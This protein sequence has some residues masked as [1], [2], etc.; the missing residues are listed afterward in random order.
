MYRKKQDESLTSISG[1]CSNS[2]CRHHV[3]AVVVGSADLIRGFNR[4]HPRDPSLRIGRHA[5]IEWRNE[6]CSRSR[7]HEFPP[8]LLFL[9]CH[10][11]AG[12]GGY[13]H[14]WD[15]RAVFH[16]LV[17]HHPEALEAL[18]RTDGTTF[19]GRRRGAMFEP[20]GRREGKS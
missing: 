14:L 13:S 17:T 11:K 20:V 19:D 5:H 16:D 7:Q 9:S 3:H 12:D 18:M 15:G 6:V 10:T 8:R 2:I 4:G 1:K